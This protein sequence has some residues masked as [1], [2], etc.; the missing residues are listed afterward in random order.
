VSNPSNRALINQVAF[1]AVK[2]VV[3]LDPG[4]RHSW[5]KDIHNLSQCEFKLIQEH[6][7]SDAELNEAGTLSSRMI[8]SLFSSKNG[9]ILINPYFKGCGYI[10]SCFGDALTDNLRFIELKD[11]DRPFRSY[12]FRQL[13]VYAA[14][15]MNAGGGVAKEI[16]VINSRRGVSVAVQ[17]SDFSHEVSGRSSYDLLSEVVRSISDVAVYQN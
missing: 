3:N 17:F 14:L 4:S 10:N 16:Q 5:V 2:E 12:E 7:L 9:K 8:T 6:W 15:H 11:G 1:E 13:I